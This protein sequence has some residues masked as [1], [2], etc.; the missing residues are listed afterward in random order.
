MSDVYAPVVPAVGVWWD[1]TATLTAV[2]TALRLVQADIDEARL[3]RC[4]AAAGRAINEHADHAVAIA[5]G[6]AGAAMQE[7]LE[8][9]AVN[10][11]RGLPAVDDTV[12]ALIGPAVERWGLA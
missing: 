1:P 5:L 9:G 7:A 12:S 4:I 2:L 10:L 6:A 3:E 11:Y 8:H